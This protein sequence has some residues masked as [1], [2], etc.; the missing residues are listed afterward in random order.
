MKTNL[1]RLLRWFLCV[2]IAVLAVYFLS[3]YLLSSPIVY[4]LMCLSLFI[5]LAPLF[6][7]E[8]IDMKNNK[9][10]NQ[11]ISLKKRNTLTSDIILDLFNQ[12][13]DA[14]KYSYIDFLKSF[15]LYV[16]KADIDEK[17][18]N[19]ILGLV[20]PIIEDQMKKEPF[21]GVNDAEKRL[22]EAIQG[23][24]NKNDYDGVKQNLISLSDKLKENQKE[25]K[26]S[27]II[28]YWSIFLAVLSI[29]IT[30][31]I[32]YTDS[33]LPKRDDKVRKDAQIEY[34][35]TMESRSVNTTSINSNNSTK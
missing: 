25:L 27:R 13:Y 24:A 29:I 11:L 33:Y 30:I 17:N 6:F 12:Q 32:W 7:W 19:E 1:F 9:V 34:E 4:V 10:F 23:S 14:N 5:I 16:S 8:P 28:N 15:R 22:L 35:K 2:S 18:T 31:S 3:A 21:S 20:N 26:S